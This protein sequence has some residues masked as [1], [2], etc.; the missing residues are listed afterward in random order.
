MNDSPEEIRNERQRRLRNAF[1]EI[2]TPDDVCQR[3][4]KAAT[5]KKLTA[6]EG[7]ST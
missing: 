2:M 1:W 3:V 7:G 4:Q 5:V 6:P